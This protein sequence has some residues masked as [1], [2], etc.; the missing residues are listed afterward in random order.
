MSDPI[1][2]DVE[3]IGINKVEN[4]LNGMALRASQMK[5]AMNVAAQVMLTSVREN[6][7]SGGR[8]TR[9]KGLAES[10][11][12]NR[13]GEKP[14]TVAG[15]RGGLKGSLHTDATTNEAIVGTDKPYAAIHNFGGFAGRGYSV[16]IPKR[17][18]L[19]FQSDDMP[20]IQAAILR[21]LSPNM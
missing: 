21:Y 14:L 4:M 11:K 13:I 2:I 7:T 18:Y 12:K 10:T 3:F 16:Y 20:Q 9:W 1:K 6:F 17:E 5:P 19:M 8:P 15:M